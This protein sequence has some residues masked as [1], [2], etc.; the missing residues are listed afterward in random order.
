MAFLMILK[1]EEHENW[2]TEIQ[3]SEKTVDIWPIFN[4][5]SYGLIQLSLDKSRLTQFKIWSIVLQY[6]NV[7]ISR[8]SQTRFFQ[9]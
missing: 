2:Y 9:A 3:C 6:Y 7:V 4:I 5:R 1:T 8:L